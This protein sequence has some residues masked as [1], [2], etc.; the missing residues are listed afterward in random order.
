MMNQLHHLE[1]ALRLSENSPEMSD[2]IPNK[3]DVVQTFKNP[4][5]QKVV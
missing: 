2:C 3:Q 1:S 4:N 5:I